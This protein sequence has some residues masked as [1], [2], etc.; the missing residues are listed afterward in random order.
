MPT[1]IEAETTSRKQK[2]GVEE[3]ETAARPL[4]RRQTWQKRD[5]NEESEQE[6]KSCSSGNDIEPDHVDTGTLWQDLEFQ[7]EEKEERKE[8]EEVKIEESGTKAWVETW[9]TS[10]MSDCR[11]RRRPTKPATATEVAKN[12]KTRAEEQE[13]PGG[14]FAWCD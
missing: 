12:F 6:Q 10:S 11:P 14:K 7:H 8:D 1:A 5:W 3:S 2:R 4:R 13:A 9:C